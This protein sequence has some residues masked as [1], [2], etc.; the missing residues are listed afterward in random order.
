MNATMAAIGI[1]IFGGS[2]L[3]AAGEPTSV[4]SAPPAS[5]LLTDVSFE[6]YEG[7]GFS[8][9]RA[10]HIDGAGKGTIISHNGL[11]GSTTSTFKVDPM[12]VFRLLELCYRHDVFALNDRYGPPNT[13]RLNPDGRVE[14][15]GHGVA[16][17]VWMR[18]T[19]RIGGYEKSIGWMKGLGVPPPVLDELEHRIEA[20]TVPLGP[21]TP[22]S[23]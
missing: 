6:W 18:V 11:A 14:T 20:A 3:A 9:G 1:V 15:L 19:I 8:G 23:K 2:S 16:D 22:N 13:V 10:I 21:S 12:E 17:A 5:Y 7:G 4:Q